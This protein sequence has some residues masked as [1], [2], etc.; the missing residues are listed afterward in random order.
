MMLEVHLESENPQIERRDVLGIFTVSLKV[1][2]VIVAV[3][4]T[5][6]PEASGQWEGEEADEDKSVWQRVLMATG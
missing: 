1:R 4:L 6:V 5:R 3:F 2:V